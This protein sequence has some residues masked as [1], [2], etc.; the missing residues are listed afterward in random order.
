MFML[1]D[2][3]SRARTPFTIATIDSNETMRGVPT[4]SPRPGKRIDFTPFNQM[5]RN[6]IAKSAQRMAAN[7]RTADRIFMAKSF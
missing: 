5:R 1:L 3:I 4:I 6:P 7:V 2:L